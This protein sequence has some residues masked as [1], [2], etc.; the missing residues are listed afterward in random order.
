MQ[1]HVLLLLGNAEE[2]ALNRELGLRPHEDRFPNLMILLLL[3][4]AKL[5]SYTWTFGMA[6]CKLLYYMQTVT[7]VCSVLNLTALSIERWFKLQSYR[8]TWVG[9]TQN[10]GVPPN[11]RAVTVATYSNT[12]A[13]WWNIPYQSQLNL[14]P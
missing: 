12:K 10:L 8:V 1:V 7:V 3:Q 9:L 6:A 4:V 14:R 2:H 13:G 5:F 11:W